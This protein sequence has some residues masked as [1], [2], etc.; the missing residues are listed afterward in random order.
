M[1]H[2]ETNN[3]VRPVIESPPSTY[4]YLLSHFGPLLTLKHLA[5]VMHTT[6]A[7]LRMTL[8]RRRQPMAVGLSGARRRLGRRVYFDAR[9]IAE[10]IDGDPPVTRDESN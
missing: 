5:E 10:L 7:G 3:Q 1:T 6:P 2:A 9:R 8:A 4:Q